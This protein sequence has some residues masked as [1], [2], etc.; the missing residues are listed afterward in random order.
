MIIGV[1]HEDCSLDFSTIV[2]RD[3][4]L[5]EICSQPGPRSENWAGPGNDKW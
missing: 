5:S 3:N 2:I 1:V 4:E